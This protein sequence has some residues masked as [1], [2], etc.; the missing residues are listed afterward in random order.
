MS[1]PGEL[2]AELAKVR[3][4]LLAL[5]SDARSID[6]NIKAATEDVVRLDESLKIMSHTQ[7]SLK[8]AIL[9]T[10]DSL[11]RLDET[12]RKRQPR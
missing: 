12:V 4:D 8:A 7:T 1:L 9:V 3:K 11:D 2:T 6:D 10:L 5:M